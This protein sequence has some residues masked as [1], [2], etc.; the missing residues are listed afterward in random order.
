MASGFS[1][2][3]LKYA[4]ILGSRVSQLVRSL[5]HSCIYDLIFA[6]SIS[7]TPSFLLFGKKVSHNLLNSVKTSLS[8][9][10]LEPPIED[11]LPKRSNEITSGGITI[12]VL[13]IIFAVFDG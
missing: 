13:L 8:Y 1:F 2:Q 10:L 11:S 5:P 7:D 12:P 9:F 6:M 4:D 3:N